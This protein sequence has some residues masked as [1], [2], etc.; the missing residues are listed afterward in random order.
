MMVLARLQE[1]GV[2]GER[3]REGPPVVRSDLRGVEVRVIA[4]CTAGAG[5]ATT[6]A[7]LEALVD[8][9]I[10]EA[11]TAREA[12]E[13]PAPA[14]V[15]ELDEPAPAGR[16]FAE[17]GLD[18]TLLGASPTTVFAPAL[19]VGVGWQRGS[20]LLRLGA[21]A[22]V[23]TAPAQRAALEAAASAAWPVGAWEVGPQLR[24]R[25]ASAS[26][27]DHWLEQAFTLGVQATRCPWRRADA[28]G[29]VCVGGAVLPLGVR[30]VAGGVSGG[31]P[32]RTAWEAHAAREAQVGLSVRYG[33]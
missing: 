24:W 30:H 31:V 3:L 17:G 11:L 10:A 7:E 5:A 28:R 9:R 2:P 18:A 23:G 19:L 16:L 22:A 1:L 26:P 6:R 27:G 8:R 33:R 29:E 21:G 13:A 12:R 32:V 14:P 25:L 15:A 4:G 20:T